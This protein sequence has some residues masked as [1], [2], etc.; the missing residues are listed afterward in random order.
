ML[1]TKIDQPDAYGN[2]GSS[3]TGVV[4]DKLFSNPEIF[5]KLFAPSAEDAPKIED[6]I[7]RISVVIGVISSTRRIKTEEFQEY[8]TEVYLLL[9][10]TFPWVSISPTC[11]AVLA[12]SAEVIALN[13]GYGLGLCS[14][15]PSEAVHKLIR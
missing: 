7:L 8:C 13:G 11:H 12:H 10:E 3:D 15:Q 14:E 2:G 5:A 6:L 4:A 1:A 9:L